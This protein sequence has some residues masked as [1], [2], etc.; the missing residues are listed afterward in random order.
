MY[1]D[2]VEYLL[3]KQGQKIAVRKDPQLWKDEGED[4]PIEG[5][6]S[7]TLEHFK[8]MRDKY[9]WS[10]DDYLLVSFMRVPGQGN[11]MWVESLC[12]VYNDSEDTYV[13]V[14][15][16]MYEDYGQ[17]YSVSIPNQHEVYKQAYFGWDSALHDSLIYDLENGRTV[18]KQIGGV[19]K[20][21][22]S[23]EP[24]A[25]L[26]T[27]LHNIDPYDVRVYSFVMRGRDGQASYTL[28]MDYLGKMYTAWGDLASTIN[29]CWLMTPTLW[30]KS[31]VEDGMAFRLHTTVKAGMI[32][33]KSPKSSFVD[34][35]DKNGWTIIE[36][37]N[38]GI[39]DDGDDLIQ[40]FDEF[41][42]Q[43]LGG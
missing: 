5:T 41:I 13:M 7:V 35:A 23:Y 32:Y 16:M 17:D 30:L 19:W 15:E 14:P 42:L 26:I 27:A 33:G 3:S 8:K 24:R 11:Y 10:T 9:F 25:S 40:K 4:Q 38:V 34:V 22:V 28:D 20:Q 18:F 29:K 37:P 21:V 2:M 39:M 43:T 1:A 31:N 36:V 6:E 12:E